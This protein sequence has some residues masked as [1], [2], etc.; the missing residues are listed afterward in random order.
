MSNIKDV[1]AREILDSRG[2]PTVE[3]DVTLESGV[4]ATAAVPSGASTGTFEALELRDGDQ[5]RYGGLGVQMAVQNVNA[6]IRQAV[7]GMD[8]FEQKAVDKAML[9]LDGTPNKSNLGANAILGVSLAVCRAAAMEKG[10]PLYQ[11]IRE[12]FSFKGKKFSLPIPMFNVINGGKH[13]DSGLSIQEYK[14]VP[15]GVA[16]FKEQLRAGS[17]VFHALK[18]LLEAENMSTGVG[19]EG[20]FAP[21]LESNAKALE[22]INRAIEKA[23]YIPGE[24]VSVGIDAAASSFYSETESQYVFRPE[25]VNLNREMLVNIYAEWIQKYHVI[26]IEDGLNEN[27]W[28]GWRAM[29][30]KLGG[31]VMLIGDDL[32]VTN[33][34]RLKTAIAEKACNSVL[35]KVNQIGSLSETVDCIKLAQKQ[36]MKTVISHRSGETTDDFIAD[37]AVGAGAEYIKSGSLSRGE[38]ICKYNRLLRIEE[39]LD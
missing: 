4:V 12:A 25:N 18:K 20:G 21:R 34:E 35:I 38:R 19:D 29:N 6:K 9:K 11:Y 33:V 22:A 5:K 26:S 13:S 1:V 17:E 24:Q 37:L 2:N 39:R 16:S 36:G 30:E 23:G 15:S 27:D 7:I 8:A 3:V 28:S 31:K 14:L 10:Q 32:L